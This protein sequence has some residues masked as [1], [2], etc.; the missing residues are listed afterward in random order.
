MQTPQIRTPDYQGYADR[1]TPALDRLLVGFQEKRQREAE[2][3]QFARKKVLMNAQQD[4]QREMNVDNQDFQREINADQKALQL[5]VMGKKFGHTEDMADRNES[6]Q[7]GENELNRGHDFAVADKRHENAMELAQMKLGQR[8]EAQ[9]ASAHQSAMEKFQSEFKDEYG[10]MLD[11]ADAD[12]RLEMGQDGQPIVSI[13]GA[14]FGGE[15]SAHE[16][17]EFDRFKRLTRGHRRLY[18]SFKDAEGMKGDARR[19]T[20]EN[21]SA[22]P[23]PVPHEGENFNYYPY[24]TYRTN[25]RDALRR[26]DVNENVFAQGVLN[27]TNLLDTRDVVEEKELDPFQARNHLIMGGPITI[28]IDESGDSD[29][30]FDF[31]NLTYGQLSDLRN[32]LMSD[33]RASDKA[34]RNERHESIRARNVNVLADINKRMDMYETIINEGAKKLNIGDGEALRQLRL[35]TGEIRQD[36]V[37]TY[38]RRPNS[39]NSTATQQQ[40]QLGIFQ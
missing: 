17:L 19:I 5:K 12:Y 25:V 24:D 32:N 29:Y 4:F 14:G 8:R 26:G 35:N 20:D 13:N 30:I 16:R 2:E 23:I 11:V 18:Q 34:N 37:G 21:S 22:E 36:D 3:R 40:Q 33:V 7:S 31:E 15:G 38:I 27:E 28:D 9:G 39:N 10:D 6:F 1:V